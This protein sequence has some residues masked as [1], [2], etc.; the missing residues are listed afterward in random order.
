MICKNSDPDG[1]GAPDQ[2]KRSATGQFKKGASGNPS[3]VRKDH[4][5][6]IEIP[7]ESP[8]D[9]IRIDGWMSA[10][11]GIGTARDKRTTHHHRSPHT[12]SYEQTAELWETDDMFAR[13]IEAPGQEAFR[14]GYEITI[15]NEGKYDDLKE[16]LEERVEELG[17]DHAVETLLQYETAYGGGAILL[18]T[19][20]PGALQE[21]LDESKVRSLDWINVLE[22]LEI[23]P[24]SYY[25]NP[26]EPKYGYPEYYQLIPTGM[27]GPIGIPGLASTTPIRD[28]QY[29]H[30]SRLIVFGGIKVSKRIRTLN[31]VSQF[32]GTPAHLR[33]QE[34]LRDFQ[35]SWSSAG[36]I[37][38][39]VSQPVISINNLM[40]MVAKEPQQ[41]LKRMMALEL[42]RSTARALLI[43]GKTEKFERV[44][45]NLAGVSDLLDRICQRLAAAIGMPLSVLMG[46]SPASLGAPGEQEMTQWY[47]KIRSLQRRKLGPVIRRIVKLLMQTMRKR[48]LPKKWGIRWNELVRMTDAQRAE[49]RLTQGRAD[50]LYVKMGAT[51]P[52]EIR[53]SRFVGEYS[54]ETQ[55]Q[56]NKK[57][58]GFIA[59]LPAGVLPGAM[60]TANVVS[61]LEAAQL[62]GTGSIPKPPAMGPNAHSVSG[63]A[64]K[65]PTASPLGANPTQ[66]GDTANGKENRDAADPHSAAGEVEYQQA[67]LLRAQRNKAS[68]ATVALM[69]K[70]IE[71]A[72]SEA[73][74]CAAGTCGPDCLY[75]HP[76]RVDNDGPGK[77]VDFGG[78]MVTVESPKGSTRE[79]TDSDGT[80]GTTKMRYDYGYLNS[81]AGTDGDAVDVYLGPSPDAPWVYVVHQMMKSSDFTRYDEDKVMLGFDSANHAKDAY[82]RQYDD[83]SFM[84]G[85]SIMS[86]AEFRRR[87]AT[88]PASMI[89]NDEDGRAATA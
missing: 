28:I 19:N 11:T 84:G 2:P 88:R 89:A 74:E 46:Y 13:A 79:W 44:T 23:M 87:L 21:P 53:R 76:D 25:G 62:A 35:I 82:L 3:G 73:A 22:P 83:E 38:T 17:V 5:D 49:S 86:T 10:F 80:T 18:G 63:Y 68:P 31:A 9:Q 14:E 61:A 71:I 12:P 42:S 66:G 69:E 27:V 34:P 54:Y 36:L 55:V 29:I 75:D 47:N 59:P 58:P 37:M 64:R 8:V 51:T 72:Q 6:P 1:D 67:M 78:F 81:T 16:K 20:D 43:D 85:M 39:D 77:T 45:T 7:V 41:L 32:W 4:R 52:D 60:P 15:S 30:E 50:T 65:N 48:K 57:A 40:Q 56:E 33:F 70:L 26:E 24:V